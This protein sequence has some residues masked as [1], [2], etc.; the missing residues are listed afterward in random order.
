M[1]IDDI[2]R[3]VEAAEGSP[4]LQA[5]LTQAKDV[6]AL[7]R[8]AGQEGFQF[9]AEELRTAVSTLKQAKELG[10][11]QLAKVAGGFNF[12]FNFLN[13]LPAVQQILIGL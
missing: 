12:S 2:R 4:E 3:L 13:F 11:E 5:K 8:V 10:D 9:S 7:V 1:A 6:D